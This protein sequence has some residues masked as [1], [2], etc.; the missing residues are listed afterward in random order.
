MEISSCFIFQEDKNV[1]RQESR[2]RPRKVMRGL[3]VDSSHLGKLSNIPVITNILTQIRH[4]RKYLIAD[5]RWLKVFT[6]IMSH[7]EETRLPSVTLLLIKKVLFSLYFPW[8]KIHFILLTLYQSEIYGMGLY[9]TGL[10]EDDIDDL[11][12]KIPEVDLEV[13]DIDMGGDGGMN[14]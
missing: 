5:R 6:V 2:D 12:F 13:P 10:S 9:L 7:I 8:G 11:D 3:T 1:K 4:N 14:L